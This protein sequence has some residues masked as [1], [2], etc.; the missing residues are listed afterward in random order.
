[1]CKPSQNY[2]S[3]NNH[4]QFA[5]HRGKHEQHPTTKSSSN[6]CNRG[7]VTSTP[8]PHTCWHINF[9]YKVGPTIP[10]VSFDT[11]NIQFCKHEHRPTLSHCSTI[12]NLHIGAKTGRPTCP[13][14]QRQQQPSLCQR[15]GR[16]RL[17]PMAS[18]DKLSATEPGISDRV[19]HCT[20][21]CADI[22][23][24][25]A[26]LL[27]NQLPHELKAQ[28]V[29]TSYQDNQKC[30]VQD[31]AIASARRAVHPNHLPHLQCTAAVTSLPD[32]GLT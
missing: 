24:S 1:M 31:L 4:E 32:T 25:V 20:L 3:L 17:L 27:G 11:K 22:K 15:A 10:V 19:A 12:N 23:S 18:H 16:W 2:C 21:F 13:P 29:H 5:W 28:R 8:V 7:V 14:I 6:L 9:R 26:T 30:Q